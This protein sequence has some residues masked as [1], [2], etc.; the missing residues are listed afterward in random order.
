MVCF[1]VN[2]KMLMHYPLTKQLSRAERIIMFIYY[3]DV[4]L[5]Y[6]YNVEVN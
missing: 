4:Q 3:I 2:F 5:Q 1:V 6:A